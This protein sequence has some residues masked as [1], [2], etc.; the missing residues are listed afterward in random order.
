MTEPLEPKQKTT[1]WDGESPPVSQNVAK[2]IVNTTACNTTCTV[3]TVKHGKAN[4]YRYHNYEK[5]VNR[6]ANIPLTYGL[7]H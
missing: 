2:K 3:V 4:I 6:L 7:S 5:V 1:L